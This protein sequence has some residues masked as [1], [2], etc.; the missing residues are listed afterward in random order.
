INEAL[1]LSEREEHNMGILLD[2]IHE[3]YS[4]NMDDFSKKIIISQ[5]EVLLNYA[6]RYYKRQFITRE[7]SNHELLTRFEELLEMYF[8]ETDDKERGLPTVQYFCE[9][10][11][12]TP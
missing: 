11:N 10:L 8:D 9:K 12:T 7:R 2:N 6:D 5:I 4:K 3:E 1:F